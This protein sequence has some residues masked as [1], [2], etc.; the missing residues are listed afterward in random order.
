MTVLNIALPILTAAAGGL[1]YLHQKGIR[2]EGE[3]KREEMLKLKEA[4]DANKEKEG[5][6]EAVTVLQAAQYDLIVTN[7]C[8]YCASTVDGP[9]VL[10][11]YAGG[12]ILISG[13]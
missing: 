5:Q 8:N 7:K 4:K 1:N 10:A 11:C 6:A 3:A 12:L 9:C 13:K 2:E